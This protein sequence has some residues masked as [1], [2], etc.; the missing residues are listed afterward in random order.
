MLPIRTYSFITRVKSLGV[1]SH[2]ASHET[3]PSNTNCQ[4]MLFHACRMQPK[5]TLLTPITET[6]FL[7]VQKKKMPE[8]KSK[9]SYLE[10]ITQWSKRKNDKKQNRAQTLRKRFKRIKKKNCWSF[11]MTRSITE[12]H[13]MITMTASYLIVYIQNTYSRWFQNQRQQQSE[14]LLATTCLV[15]QRALP[16]ELRRGIVDQGK[17][18]IGDV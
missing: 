1:R 11:C 14:N 10:T 5:S 17:N 18:K 9:K 2:G 7:L 12:Q 6:S 13:K 15:D 16:P 4:A 3:N 8:R